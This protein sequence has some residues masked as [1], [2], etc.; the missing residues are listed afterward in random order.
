MSIAVFLALCAPVVLVPVLRSAP[1]RHLADHL[2]PSWSAAVLAAALVGFTA[3]TLVGLG[4]LIGLGASGW[5]PVRVGRTWSLAAAFGGRPVVVAHLG[6]VLAVAGAVAAAVVLVRVGRAL[7]SVREQYRAGRRLVPAGTPPGSLIEMPGAPCAAQALPV[8]GGQVLVDAGRWASLPQRHRDVVLAHERSHLRHRHD[9]Y[10]VVAA[11]ATAGNPLLGPLGRTLTYTLERWA[12]EDAAA[13]SGRTT[14]AHAVAA[15]ALAAPRP[16]A[17]VLGVG[18]GVVPRR[19]SALLES[20]AAPTV[21]RPGAATALLVV[22]TLGAAAGLATH[23]WVDLLQ[24]VAT[25]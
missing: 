4:L 21:S 15:V 20:P 1:G 17:A 7:A 9:L 25:R 10:L 3:V 2:R 6:T 13:A 8:R 24:I 19:V 16:A 14:A 12:D 18:G 5:N 23:A 11:L 22:L